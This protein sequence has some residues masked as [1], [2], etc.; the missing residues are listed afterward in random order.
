M[1]STTT[2]PGPTSDIVTMEVPEPVASTTMPVPEQS[3]VTTAETGT[4][5]TPEPDEA[6]AP[7]DAPKGYED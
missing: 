3:P 5:A 4:D 1:R 2:T 6:P 7:T